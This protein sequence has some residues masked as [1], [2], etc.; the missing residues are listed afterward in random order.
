MWTKTLSRLYNQDE[1][2][3][4]EKQVVEFLEDT[5]KK[6]LNIEEEITQTLISPSNKAQH[7][8]KSKSYGGGNKRL[9]STLA[10]SF[11]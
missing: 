7:R 8:G 6:S 10:N 11:L 9:N 2:D 3:K 1:K 4:L 5:N